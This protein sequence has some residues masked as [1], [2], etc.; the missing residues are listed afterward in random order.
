MVERLPELRVAL[1]VKRQIMITSYDNLMELK[2]H[3]DKLKQLALFERLV[4][5]HEVEPWFHC[6]VQR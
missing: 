3:I 5:P 6:W 2:S 4:W 1:I